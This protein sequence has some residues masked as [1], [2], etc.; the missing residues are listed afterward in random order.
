MHCP[1]SVLLAPSACLGLAVGLYAVETQHAS[2]PTPMESPPQN[3]RRSPQPPGAGV[4]MR[5]DPHL[6]FP[7]QLHCNYRKIFI[8]CRGLLGQ[9]TVLALAP[10]PWGCTRGGTLRGV[11]KSDAHSGMRCM[12][13]LGRAV[14]WRAFPCGVRESFRPLF[15]YLNSPLNSGHGAYTSVTGWV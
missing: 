14:A 2:P 15:A 9:V 3:A 13:N 10:P 8:Q 11:Q 5:E 12:Y 1:Y 7:L 6:T 4:T